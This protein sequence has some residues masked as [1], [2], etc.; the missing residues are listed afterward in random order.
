MLGS[1]DIIMD[2]NKPED[3]DNGASTV[4][5]PDKGKLDSLDLIESLPKVAV[6][7]C[8]IGQKVRYNGAAKTHQWVNDYLL[9]N[10]DVDSFCPELSMG[11]GTP[12]ESLRIITKDN[13]HLRLIGNESGID[14]TESMLNTSEKIIER[15]PPDLD[16]VILMS[17]SPSCGPE[18]VK[19]YDKNNSPFSNGEGFFSREV[20]RKLQDVIVIDAGRLFDSDQRSLFLMRLY[21]IR[22]F[23]NLRKNRKNLQIFHQRHKFLL[24][25]FNRDLYKRLGQIAGEASDIENSFATYKKTLHLL[26]SKELERGVMSDSLMHLYSFVKKDLPTAQKEFIIK[27]IREFREGNTSVSVPLNL[28]WFSNQLVN[29]NYLS[30]QFIFYPY[31]QKLVD[32]VSNLKMK[33]GNERRSG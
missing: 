14:F 16:A 3:I 28:I 17:K 26:L 21:T 11:L 5:A 7:G 25:S 31:P 8:L 12:R 10:V 29:S 19:V 2:S 13:K 32:Q 33:V 30:K 22:R 6:S 1:T 24:A 9:P 20:R 18:N 27:S 23:K 15:L 4:F